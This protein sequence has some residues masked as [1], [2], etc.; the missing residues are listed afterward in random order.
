MK[1]YIFS[2]GTLQKEKVQLALFGRLLHGTK[3]QLRGYRLTP[4]EI[5]DQAALT[6]SGQRFHT[7]AT[8]SNN[9]NDIIPGIVY[10][11]TEEELLATDTYEHDY[12]RS[13]VKLDSGK[14]AW[15]YL[16]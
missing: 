14:D 13:L 16:G 12:K 2:Y 5:T 9:I 7:I 11:V 3:D 1:Q 6:I 8:L 4:I 10:L 15:V